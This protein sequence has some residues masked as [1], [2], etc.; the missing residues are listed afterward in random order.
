MMD[1]ILINFQIN[2]KVVI[3]GVRDASQ[4]KNVLNAMINY[5]C[6]TVNAILYAQKDTLIPNLLEN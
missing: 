2:V 4:K 1:I 5:T 3:N 6:I